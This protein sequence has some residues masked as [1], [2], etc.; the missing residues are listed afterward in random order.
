[1]ASGGLDDG[2]ANLE[3][4][5]SVLT[6]T[7]DRVEQTTSTLESHAEALDDLEDT[8]EE[9]LGAFADDVDDFTDQLDSTEEEAVAEIRGLGEAAREA[10]DGALAQAESDLRE[11]ESSF[12]DQTTRS[13]E[14]LDSR[15]GSLVDSGYGGFLGAV[16]RL[17]GELNDARQEVDTGF[18][19]FEGAAGTL[20]DE[21]SSAIEDA[22]AKTE[23]ATTWVEQ[24]ESELAD[25]VAGFVG[26]LEAALSDA[27]ADQAS[28]GD[29]AEQLYASMAEAAEAEGKDLQ[30]QVEQLLDEASGFV[31]Q[32]ASDQ[33][34]QPAELVLQEP[35]PTLDSELD[36]LS[37]V[38]DEASGTTADL[39]PLVGELV[40]AVSIVGTI[41]EMLNAME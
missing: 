19:D 24:H 39:E 11:A 2:V 16:D 26:D 33:L 34:D 10:A 5:I 6:S 17:G 4:F 35:M 22:S 32:A 27:L 15:E 8:A 21:T 25:Q 1:M 30:D 29:E 38:L 36:G 37:D 13:A 12:E 31:A 23:E 14:S 41:D 28:V 3:R 18:E 7:T 20:G 9:K 40:T